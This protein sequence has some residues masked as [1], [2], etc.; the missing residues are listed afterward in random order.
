MN[1]KWTE[2]HGRPNGGDRDQPMVTLSRR[3]VLTM[4]KAAYEALGSPATVKLMYEEDRRMIGIMPHD[5]RRANA[6]PVKQC[7]G[8]ASNSRRIYLHP[9]CT[10]NGI[11]IRRTLLF[12]EIDIDRV[13]MMRLELNRTVTIGKA[14]RE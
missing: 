14:A 5:E 11:D 8:K 1:E 7:S 9:F 10:H 2:F 6:F 3:N 13:G 12:N 4:N